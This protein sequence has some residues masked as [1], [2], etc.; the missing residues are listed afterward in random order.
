MQ[1]ILFSLLVIT[2]A[3]TAHAQQINWAFD[4][5]SE[6]SSSDDDRGYAIALDDN[7]NIYI[8][9][10]F[11]Q[12][13]DFNPAAATNNLTSNG[14][15]DIFV[16]KYSRT[17]AY[18]WAFNIGS[19]TADYG[20]GIAVDAA[21]NV[22]ITGDF[23]GTA[24]FNPNPNA[25]N[26]LTANENDDIF[27]AKYTTNGDYQWA[28]NI[29]GGN[30]SGLDIALD[31]AA[32]VYVTG[33]FGGT[34]DFNPDPNTT[35]NLTSAGNEDI[36]VAKYNS[37]GLYQW[38]FNIGGTAIDKGFGIA[39]DAAANVYVTGS[40]EGVTDFNPSGSTAN[41]FTNG[42][43]DI[44]VAK[45]T[46]S[47][48]FLWARSK[49]SF[50]FD[51]GLDLA[52]DFAANIYTTGYFLDNGVTDIFVSKYNSNGDELWE[53]KIG[54]LFYN[55]GTGIA[56][57]TANNIY[58]TGIFEGTADFNPDDS[59]TN[60]LTTNGVFDIFVGKYNSNGEYEWAFNIGGSSI[61]HG[62]GIAVNDK[63]EPFIT[64]WFSGTNVNFNPNA[65][66]VI[67][68]STS[69]LSDENIYIAAASYYIFTNVQSPNQDKAVQI[70]PNPV[71]NQLNIM[72]GK[73]RATIY[74]VLGQAIMECTISDDLHTI[75]TSRLTQGQYF[76]RIQKKDGSLITQ[77]FIK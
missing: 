22:Y 73:G 38:A 26:N 63:A 7:D 77:P 19:A 1:N 52:V 29:G 47:G 15:D 9:G 16:A 46:S 53:F 11:E 13:A 3:T 31:A 37:N 32:N 12:T 61:D 72:N 28:F 39:L 67:N 41:L 4:I 54:G 44:F 57:D 5:G 43:S 70:F 40:F 49:G 66:G 65:G 30:D 68:L 64:G 35:D 33:F 48:S 42:L 51:S 24:D 62:Q 36:F 14:G 6:T 25:T 17:G 2:L 34:A 45:Y 23:S 76:I 21:A 20:Y 71:L 74:N 27:I 58:V 18:Q 75:N 50:D 55:Q 56:I 10:K 69:G 60:E 8:I 59:L